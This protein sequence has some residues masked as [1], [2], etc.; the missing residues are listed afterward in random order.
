MIAIA[1]LMNIFEVKPSLKIPFIYVRNRE[2][3][4]VSLYYKANSN[5]NPSGVEEN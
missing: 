3:G 5:D 4:K 1:P 2:T